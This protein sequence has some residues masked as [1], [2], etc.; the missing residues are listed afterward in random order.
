MVGRNEK[1]PARAEYFEK[2][3]IFHALR[4]YESRKQFYGE[5]HELVAKDMFTPTA[6][7]EKTSGNKARCWQKRFK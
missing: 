7:S 5:H 1:N 4:A 2:K 6:F 3:Q